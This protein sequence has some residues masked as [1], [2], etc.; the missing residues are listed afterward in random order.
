MMD[1]L[2]GGMPPALKVGMNHLPAGMNSIGSTD[3]AGKAA[4]GVDVA[5]SRDNTPFNIKAVIF[6]PN[7]IVIF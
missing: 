5:T 3:G 4:A 6:E 2:G 1:H 7:L